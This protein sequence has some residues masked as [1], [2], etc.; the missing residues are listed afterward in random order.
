VDG[1][2][3][4]LILA[5]LIPLSIVAAII[6][7]RAKARIRAHTRYIGTTLPYAAT[8]IGRLPDGLVDDSISGVPIQL[9]LPFKEMYEYIRRVLED[10]FNK[11]VESPE[12]DEF[13]RKIL[14]LLEHNPIPLIAYAFNEDTV[15]VQFNHVEGTLDQYQLGPSMKRLESVRQEGKLPHIFVAGALYPYPEKI[16]VPGGLREAVVT[17]IPFLKRGGESPRDVDL[18]FFDPLDLSEDSLSIVNLT[19]PDRA[20][21]AQWVQFAIDYAGSHNLYHKYALTQMQLSSSEKRNEDSKRLMEQLNERIRRLQRIAG[22]RQLPDPMT[23]FIQI[24]LTYILWHFGGLALAAILAFMFGV[25]KTIDALSLGFLIVAVNIVS[26]VG[27]L[28]V[29]YLRI[30]RQSK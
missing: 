10:T 1:W 25:G 26:L 8:L 9:S 14:P 29:S 12:K 17:R 21:L 30:V 7:D 5:L 24:S 19:E 15:V 16:S 23:G 20:E 4:W 28:I 3:L 11:M 27:G 18:F 2:D 22:V 13:A 6:F